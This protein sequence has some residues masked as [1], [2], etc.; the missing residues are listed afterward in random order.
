M[1]PGKIRHTTIV[2]LTLFSAI[3]CSRKLELKDLK[4]IHK[5]GVTGIDSI[6]YINVG[7]TLRIRAELQGGEGNV[8]DTNRYELSWA[9]YQPG[10]FEKLVMPDL[11]F[12]ATKSTI[13]E[14]N[15]YFRITD[16]QTGLFTQQPFKVSILTP[17]KEGWYVLCD[18]GNNHSRLDMLSYN[19]AGTYSA[20]PDVMTKMGA[21]YELKGKPV[22][23][24]Y[25]ITYLNFTFESAIVVTDQDAVQLNPSLLKVQRRL[26]DAFPVSANFRPA[27]FTALYSYNAGLFNVNGAIYYSGP[28]YVGDAAGPVSRSAADATPLKA[29]PQMASSEDFFR[30]QIA[31]MV[32]F[33]DNQQ[34]F[35]TISGLDRVAP[36]PVPLGNGSL[37]NFQVHKKLVSLL[38]TPYNGGECYAVLQDNAA[39]TRYLAIFNAKGQ[40]RYFGE[41]KG[42][43]IEQASLFAVSGEFGYLFY[44]S[45][46]KVYEF[47]PVN[48]TNPLVADLG[49]KNIS[50]LRAPRFPLSITYSEPRI[51]DLSRKLIIGTYEEANIGTSGMIGIYDVPAANKPLVLKDQYSGFGKVI[52]MCYKEAL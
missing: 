9:Y 21:P 44:N 22:S 27:S 46:G 31:Y 4:D 32:I 19:P 34:A 26:S 40:Q 28:D 33:D 2:I 17:T 13:G 16:K 1:L 14:F 15:W 52:S 6:Y 50:Y 7:D 37:F 36:T 39:T 38:F 18:V 45:G 5:V 47:D 49:A 24:D 41:L 30:T 35:F 43:D 42:T 11:E 20:V 29:S 12:V 10:G 8:R 48:N 51:Q 23:V 25:A 3:A